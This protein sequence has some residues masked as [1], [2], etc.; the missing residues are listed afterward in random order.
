MRRSFHRTL[1]LLI[2]F[3]TA[4]QAES[5]LVQREP[6]IV[7]EGR[8]TISAQPYYQRLKR[9]DA[10]GSSMVAVPDGAGVLPLEERLPLSPSQLLVGR[11]DMQTVPDLVTPLFVMGMD[12]AS[13]TWFS[14]AAGGLADIGARGVVVQANRLD[15]WREL[16]QQARTIGI[17]LMLMEGDSLAQGYGIRTYPVVLMSPELAQK[18]MHE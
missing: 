6:T 3:S 8:S 11:P 12:E 9:K 7:Y 18:G 4:A 16:Q 17:D 15:H 13:L 10:T 1:A 5:L 2:T 14:R